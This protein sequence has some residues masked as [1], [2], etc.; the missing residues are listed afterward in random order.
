MHF[1]P[2][3]EY[4]KY[5]KNSEYWGSYKNFKC[6]LLSKSIAAALPGVISNEN[7]K[8]LLSESSE[9]TTVYDRI[10]KKLLIIN[11]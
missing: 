7:N 11:K 4:P 9:I 6:K 10:K 3:P 1:H 5:P 2:K 8:R